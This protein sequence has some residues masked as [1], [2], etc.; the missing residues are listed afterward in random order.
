ASMRTSNWTNA[1][2]AALGSNVAFTPEQWESLTN[3]LQTDSNPYAAITSTE[4]PTY[5]DLFQFN[6]FVK[7]DRGYVNG[8][9]ED[10]MTPE[11]FGED[12]DE[13]LA[14]YTVVTITEEEV[15]VLV[16]ITETMIVQGT[17]TTL[18]N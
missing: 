14:D 5:I 18:E 12:V 9:G 11:Q 2:I 6:F 17:E 16:P 4:I 8:S 13:I 1:Q 7:S 3:S 15:P 10:I